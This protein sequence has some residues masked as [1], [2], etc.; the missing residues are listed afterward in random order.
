MSTATPI[1]P[2][3]DEPVTAAAVLD[4]IAALLAN[5]PDWS[6][7]ELSGIADLIGNVRPHPGLIDPDADPD[8]RAAKLAAYH[9][10]LTNE[11]NPA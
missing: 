11:R 3:V 8:T 2:P 4:A 10:R 5:S 7:D 9:H 1:P 6:A